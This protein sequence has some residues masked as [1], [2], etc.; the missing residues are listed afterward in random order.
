MLK[1]ELIPSLLVIIMGSIDCI[2]TVIGIRLPWSYR[3]KPL[4]G[5]HSQHKHWSILSCQDLQPP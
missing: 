3:I 2:T 4:H 5:R 1:K